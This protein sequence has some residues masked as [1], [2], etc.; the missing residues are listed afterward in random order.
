MSESVELSSLNL[1]YEGYRLRDVTREARLLASIADRG[2]EEPLEGVD[3]ADGHL[4]L[5]GFKR[6][7]CAQKLGIGIVPRNVAVSTATSMAVVLVEL[8]EPW[9]QRDICIVYRST[10]E[11]TRVEQS[12]VRFCNERIAP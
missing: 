5:N 10:E 7:R 12:F 4:L 8:R 11:L 6:C 3:T 2:I 9:V 1:R